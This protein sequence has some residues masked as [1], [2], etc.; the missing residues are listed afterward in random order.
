MAGQVAP[1]T[2][3]LRRSRSN[4]QVS[5][6]P[7]AAVNLVGQQSGNKSTL[8]D[9]QVLSMI[10]A[11]YR[12]KRDDLVPPMLD[13]V[14]WIEN[15][16]DVER[17][18]R[19]KR[20]FWMVGRP[21]PPRPLHHQKLLGREIFITEQMDMHLVWTAGCMYLKLLPHFLLEPQ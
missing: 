6:H 8:S 4:D 9:Q 3:R 19:I 21:T 13:D 14:S 12:T 5:N 15:G 16:L 11:S 10:P 7:Q 2:I 17:L 18:H 1:F 20:W